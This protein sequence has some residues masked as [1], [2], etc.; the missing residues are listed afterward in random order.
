MRLPFDGNYKITQIF[1]N[2]LIIDGVDFYGKWG[3]LG[4]NGI[5]Y[6]IPTGVNILSP[7][8]GTIKEA[9]FDAN[10]YGWY[11]KVENDIEGSILGHML[12]LDVKVGD[13][14]EEGQKVGVSDNTGA[15]TGPHL[16]WSYYRFPRDKSNGYNGFIDQTSYILIPNPTP[17]TQPSGD[18]NTIR[19]FLIS[20]GYTHTE[21]HLEVIKVLYESD[22][23]LKSGQYVIK[24][25][26]NKE[27]EN[28]QKIFDEEK[29]TWE[30]IKIEAI[31]EATTVAVNNAKIEWNKELEGQY[32]DYLKV[33]D[34][35]VFKTT[36]AILT[37]F[38]INKSTPE[39]G[40]Q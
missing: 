6:G 33:K 38:K 1:G 29:K 24:E 7:H 15:S 10:G 5:D 13:I 27:K 40:E 16:H 25:D 35:P 3:L 34:T 39:G 36:M 30:N 14:V 37:F 8:K 2:K 4:H 17:T 23:K 9:Y 31:K 28:L 12:S 26:C 11:V 22:L 18:D 20:K 32:Q 19:D 21:T